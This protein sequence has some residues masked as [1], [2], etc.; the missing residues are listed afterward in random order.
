MCVNKIR[1][2]LKKQ[3]NVKE[4]RKPTHKTE[5]KEIN[6]DK[7][8]ERMRRP[9]ITSKETPKTINPTKTLMKTNTGKKERENNSRLKI[10]PARTHIALTHP[11]KEMYFFFSL[12]CFIRC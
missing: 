7:K 9:K 5:R 3:K 10:A 11:F 2:M 4:R 6:N 1:H 12:V 8:K